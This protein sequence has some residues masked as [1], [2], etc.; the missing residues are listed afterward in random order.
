LDALVPNLSARAQQMPASPI[1]R[2]VPYADAAKARGVHVHHLNIGQPDLPTPRGMIEA[3]RAYDEAVLAY[4]PSQGL[5]ALRAAIA[6]YFAR[7]GLSVA[8]HEVNVTVGGSEALSFAFQAVTDPGDEVV[9]AEP[10]YANYLG[11][12]VSAGVTLR[13]VPASAADGFHLPPDEA[14]ERAI[15]PR[16]RAIVYSSPGN[17]TGTIY[18]RAELERLGRLA[19]KHDL[20]LIADE[21]YRE[22]AYGGV[23][24]TSALSL[25]CAAERV[26]VVDSVSKR[27]SACGAR[28]GCLVAKEKRLLDAIM[29]LCFAR[30]CPATVDQVAAVAA[31][32]T[33][34]SY[35]E[36][37][38][39]EYQRRR[40]LLVSGLNAIPGV[41]TYCPEGAFYTV[42]RLPVD[43]SDRFAEWL[44]TDFSHE[45]QTVMIAPASGFY[46]TPGLGK[47][48]ARIAYVLNCDDLSR[49]I[50]CLRVALARYPGAVALA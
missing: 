15:T 16:T 6:A 46:G 29:R 22:F 45:G 44:L 35:F 43:D 9:V 24:V 41:H 11:F 19:E 25:P 39:A 37:T 31:Y 17:P 3:Y 10:F 8:P 33:P 1:R 23:E 14:F 36:E 7:R 2:L 49:S 27:Y 13:A 18:T 20:F 34:E 28:V 38:V 21:V 30:L 50:A 32:Q 47:Q 48:E 42:V 4:G 5:P 26:L 12:A 40:D